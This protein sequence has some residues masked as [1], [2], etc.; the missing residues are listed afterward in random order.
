MPRSS[1][2]RKALNVQSLAKAIDSRIDIPPLNSKPNPAALTLPAVAW[3]VGLV[4]LATTII[5]GSLLILQPQAWTISS[6]LVTAG[7]YGMFFAA[8][9]WLL[10]RPAYRVR[11]D[12]ALG[13][14]E[15]EEIYPEPGPIAVLDCAAIAGVRVDRASTDDGFAYFVAAILRD[16]GSAPLSTNMLTPFEARHYARKIAA[17]IAA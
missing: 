4:V 8:G 2:N 3:I 13:Q 9:S 14:I 17:Q 10:L 5:Q 12:L 6:A 11:P 1:S 15:V 7:L 16:G